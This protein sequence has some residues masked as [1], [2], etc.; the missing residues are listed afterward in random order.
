MKVLFYNGSLRLGGAEKIL[1]EILK[2]LNK[3][4][5]EIDLLISDE[6]SEDNFF[7]K[8]IPDE[9]KLTYLIPENLILKTMKYKK[10]KKNLYNKIMYNYCMYK[11]QNE[12][13]RNLKKFLNHK[14]YD[15]VIDFDMGLSKNIDEV[16][17]KKKIAW[18]HSPID[19]WYKKED[20]IK[21]L[22]KR[23]K[24]Y[25]ILVTIC[26]DLKEK[27][28]ILYP[29]LKNKLVRI[30]NPFDIERI[31]KLAMTFEGIESEK[32]KYLKESYIVAVARLDNYSKDFYTLLR[33]F[34]K[35]KVS[36]I[37]EKLF[38]LGEG[39]EK[40]Q[41][42]KWIEELDL[43]D[44]VILMGGQRNPYVWMKNSQ[45]FVHSSR[46]EGLPTVLIESMIC[47]TV[48]VSSDCPTGPKEILKNGEYGKLYPVGDFNKL[49]E[50][51]IEM[52]KEKKKI[53]EFKEK[54]EL[55]I[56]DFSKENS[57]RS[58]EK[59]LRQDEANGK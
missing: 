30:Y 7:E 56:Q 29:F 50:I 17:A 41:I 52:L 23:L 10:K 59:I 24:K 3:E 20:K 42:L 32:I 21:R 13:K 36:G 16:C 5:K 22:G 2:G 14:E 15:V 46:F 58:I 33:G 27:T 34:K 18:I 35:A 26:N 25:D 39:E 57:I 9:V 28:G 48:V 44:E 54:L 6:I 1:V 49:G 45:L 37:K 40:E 51:L 4:D 43:Q 19:S 12:K 31:K 38:I 11:E 53:D 47:E 55:R 8:D